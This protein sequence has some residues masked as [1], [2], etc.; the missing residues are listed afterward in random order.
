MDPEHPVPGIGDTA[1][2]PLVF[3][4]SS[5]FF[6]VL[7]PVLNTL[8]RTQEAEADMYGINASR[9]P[10]GFAHAA[11]DLAEYRKMSPGPI[12]EWIFFDHPSGRNRIRA[13]M[14]WKAENLALVVPAQHAG[15][16]IASPRE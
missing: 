12:E 1:I 16:P 10:D 13:A 3:L 6:F 14:R 5:M 9:Q 15:G 7:S 11:L 8:V 4:V 2:L